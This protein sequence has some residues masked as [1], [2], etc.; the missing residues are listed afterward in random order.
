[1]VTQCKINYHPEWWKWYLFYWVPFCVTQQFADGINSRMLFSS[2]NSTQH[3]ELLITFC[4]G[5][6]AQNS[7]V[8]N[9]YYGSQKITN[10]RLI[11]MTLLS[12]GACIE[13]G[14]KNNSNFEAKN[15]SELWTWT[16]F[17]IVVFIFAHIQI[18]TSV[19]V[20]ANSVPYR[21]LSSLLFKTVHTILTKKSV[22]EQIS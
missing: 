10:F 16:Q 15:I 20:G 7:S 3:G 11:N 2:T 6:S 13:I 18:P 14:W 22:L 9:Q 4:N 21:K 8:G 1:M 12:V 17:L 19:I 5:N